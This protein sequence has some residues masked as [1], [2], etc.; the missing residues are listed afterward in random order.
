[1][2]E[3]LVVGIEG[4]A[5]AL[6]RKCFESIA[7][8]FQR[9][10]S[11][12]SAAASAAG[13]G[14]APTPAP[15]P[16]AASP[17]N[18]YALVGSVQRNPNFTALIAA[19]LTEDAIVAEQTNWQLSTSDG[20]SIP[21][22]AGMYCAHALVYARLPVRPSHI[23]DVPLPSLALPAPTSLAL[24][25]PRI[26]NSL[27]R[28]LSQSEAPQPVVAPIPT[29]TPPTPPTPAAP[30]PTPPSP[31]A[32]AGNVAPAPNGAAPAPPG[33]APAPAPAPSPE[34]APAPAGPA[35]ISPD[36]W[37]K[38]KAANEERLK[39]EAAER[40]KKRGAADVKNFVIPKGFKVFRMLYFSC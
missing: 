30:T 21:V 18:V 36:V 5:T 31:S 35:V 6:P 33:P 2:P 27:L 7:I 40:D 39:A 32:A 20:Q 17:S 10:V 11:D 4:S 3:L 9:P 38:V 25:Q 12:A 23:P 15:T 26:G 8:P 16:T 22:A 13:G 37:A 14:A 34:P 28:P 19:A 1:M 29:P 24:A